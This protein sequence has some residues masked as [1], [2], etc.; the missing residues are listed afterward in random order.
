MGPR[1]R[2]G[3]GGLTRR[4]VKRNDSRVAGLRKLLRHNH[5]IAA[6]SSGIRTAKYPPL[7]AV[8]WPVSPSSGEVWC[9]LVGPDWVEWAVPGPIPS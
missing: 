6:R 3:M 7:G 4:V 2:G 8:L 9:A 1:G 5:G